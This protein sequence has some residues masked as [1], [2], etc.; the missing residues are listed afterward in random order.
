[1]S[2]SFTGKD[3]ERIAEIIGSTPQIADNSYTWKVI[4]KGNGQSLVFTVYN[5]IP[6]DDNNSCSMITA[7][8][9]QGYFE[10]HCC[11]GYMIFEP[12]EVIFIQADDKSVTSL[13][14]G[15]E[16]TCSMYANIDRKILISDFTMLDPALLPAAMQLS[17][18]EEAL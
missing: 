10:L 17:L 3:I 1:M 11:T 9:Q 14:I 16:S 13:I 5:S 6:I 18:I 2:F 4:N 8:T 15:R 7:Q 12:G